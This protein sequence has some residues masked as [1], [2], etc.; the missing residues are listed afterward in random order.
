MSEQ[1]RL[2]TNL[3]NRTKMIVMTIVS[4]IICSRK[5]CLVQEKEAKQR[6]NEKEKVQGKETERETERGRE[7]ENDQD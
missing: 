7:K 5:T 3:R 1:I 4:L 2:L 6:E